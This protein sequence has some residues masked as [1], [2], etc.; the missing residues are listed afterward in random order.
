MASS[1]STWRKHP[2]KIGNAYTAKDSFDGFPTGMFLRGHDY[3][4][5]D[6][7]YSHYDDTTFFAFHERGGTAPISWRWHDDEPDSLCHQRFEIGD[8]L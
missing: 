3:V 2:F 1:G 6:V 5:D 8:G 7:G 4:F